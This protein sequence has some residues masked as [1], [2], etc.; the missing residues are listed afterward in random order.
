MSGQ[1]K[2]YLVTDEAV[3]LIGRPSV[4]KVYR[5]G[6]EVA[7]PEAENTPTLTLKAEKTQ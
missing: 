1:E 7:F 4:V 6:T 2:E 3:V 5:D